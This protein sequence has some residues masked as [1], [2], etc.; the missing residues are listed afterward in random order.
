MDVSGVVMLVAGG[1]FVAILSSLA[2]AWLADGVASV[3]AW[4]GAAG[5]RSHGAAAY[6]WCPLP[7]TPELLATM[8]G[9]DERILVDALTQAIDVTTDVVPE[10]CR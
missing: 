2:F 6:G 4:V 5:F 1:V 7:L 3:F 8:H 10:A 9:H